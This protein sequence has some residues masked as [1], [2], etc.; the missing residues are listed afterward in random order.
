VVTVASSPASG[1]EA[2]ATLRTT[3]CEDG[4]ARTGAHPKTE[5]VLL[6]P[7]T[8]VRLE[9]PL[10]HWNDSGYSRSHLSTNPLIDLSLVQVLAHRSRNL[11]RR[12]VP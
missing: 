6:V 4:A 11:Q 3:R 8:V 5:A 10:A 12:T 9:R 7:T 2:L 1:R